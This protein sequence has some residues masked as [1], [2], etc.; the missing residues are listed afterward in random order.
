MKNWKVG[1]RLAAGFGVVLI[2][3]TVVT[4]IGIWRLQAV[5]QA[6]RSMMQ[7]PLAKERLISD[8]YSNISSSIMR[9][10]AIAKSSDLT[11][12]AYFEAAASEAARNALALHA[13]VEGLLV[14]PEEKKLF[15]DIGA[16]RK[17]YEAAGAA[18]VALRAEGK[19]FQARNAFEKSYLPSSAHYLGSVR[20]LL[21]LQRQGINAIAQ[22]IEAIYLSSRAALLALSLAAL[23]CGLIGAWFITRSLLRQLG[24]EPTHAV[25]V[26]DRIA[27]GDLTGIIRVG[28]HDTFSLMHAMQTMQQNL[29]A[30]VEHIRQSA[31]TIG[32]ASNEIAVGNL[33]LSSRTEQQAGSLEETASAMQQLTSAVKK[34]ADSAIQ[35]NQLAVSASHVAVEGGRVVDQAV[36]TMATI[37]A[38]SKKVAEIISV[39]NGIA[40]Q[41]NILAL[42]AAV[43]AARAGEQGRGFAVVASEVRALAQRSAT[44][45]KEIKALID[46]S[47]GQI[48]SG[49]AQ[50]E[51]AG[52]TIGDLVADITKLSVYV[53]EISAASVEQSSGLE[54]VNQAI[55]QM[56]DVTQHNAALVEQAAAAAQSL[57][58]QATRLGQVVGAF[59]LAPSLELLRIA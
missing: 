20:K 16:N 33:D 1:T 5:A 11:L 53:A 10:T 42:N 47:V 34:N 29:A 59:K 44:A 41:T 19:L 48:V 4:G 21:Q 2:L 54:Q 23:L 9:T 37:S 13:K 7:M 27:A 8:W 6:T 22:D 17:A 24:G 55:M 28:A 57:Q 45:A 58:D 30:S 46:D 40:F 50:V 38:S 32:T 35:A 56:D 31:E 25:H 49:T 26:A 12:G 18:I 3:M 36:G 51:Q 39:I 15:A 52:A 43:E 14:T